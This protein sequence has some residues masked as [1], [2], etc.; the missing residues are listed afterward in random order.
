MECVFSTR[1]IVPRIYSGKQSRRC[2]SSPG[3]NPYLM[4]GQSCAGPPF[5]SGTSSAAALCQV[6]VGLRLARLVFANIPSVLRCATREF[7]QAPLT[8]ADGARGEL[9]RGIARMP[10]F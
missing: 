3:M 6:G 5:F 4:H 10:N 1:F 2:R 8:Q 7:T 9:Q